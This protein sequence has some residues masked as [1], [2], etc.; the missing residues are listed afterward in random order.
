MQERSLKIQIPRAHISKGS[1]EDNIRITRIDNLLFG[2]TTRETTKR[3]RSGNFEGPI[4]GPRIL[5]RIG[6]KWYAFRIAR[7][8]E[9]EIKKKPKVIYV[10]ASGK[11]YY[12]RGMLERRTHNQI[13][14][15]LLTVQIL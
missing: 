3:K 8:K 9:R 1:T 7:R 12:A 14:T 6:N 4:K 2:N 15:V 13:D 10:H 11:T 5:E